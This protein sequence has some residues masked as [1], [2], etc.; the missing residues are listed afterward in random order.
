MWETVPKDVV[1]CA[2]D[3]VGLHNQII[4]VGPSLEGHKGPISSL[5]LQSKIWIAWSNSQIPEWAP[6]SGWDFQATGERA[7]SKAFRSLK[8]HGWLRV[9]V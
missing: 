6:V 9:W 4:E 3:P 7:K 2:G 1:V 5:A 8:S